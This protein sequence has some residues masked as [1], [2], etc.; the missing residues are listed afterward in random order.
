MWEKFKAV[1]D[2]KL[3]GMWEKL[4]VAQAVVLLGLAALAIYFLKALGGFLITAVI[5]GGAG[6]GF[7]ITAAILVGVGYVLYEKFKKE[8]KDN[9]DDNGK[10]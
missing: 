6:G 10:T 2:S 4:S 1:W 7:L 3:K 9:S 8:L 5:L